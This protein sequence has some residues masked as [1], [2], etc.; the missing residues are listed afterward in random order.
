MGNSNVKRI[1][2]QNLETSIDGFHPLPIGL[3]NLWRSNHGKTSE[4]KKLMKVN[5]LLN[6]NSDKL[7]YKI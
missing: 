4:Y 3:E 5:N 6:M 7:M 2:A 1:F